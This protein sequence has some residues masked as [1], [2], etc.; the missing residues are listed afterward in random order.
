M[1]WILSLFLSRVLWS[2]EQNIVLQ[3]MHK[4]EFWI[5]IIKC[6]NKGLITCAEL[7]RF[8]EMSRLSELTFELRL[9]APR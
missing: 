5:L 3:H 8:A 7:S 2:E 6:G 1:E 4:K 9:H